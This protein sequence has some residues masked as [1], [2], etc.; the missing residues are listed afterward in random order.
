MISI[1]ARSGCRSRSLEL[2]SPTRIFGLSPSPERRRVR[3][4][5]CTEVA[6]ATEHAPNARWREGCAEP[7][8]LSVLRRTRRT[9][10]PR[11][12][13]TSPLSP[14]QITRHT[15]QSNFTRK[16]LKTND[17]HPKEVTHFFECLIPDFPLA[18]PTL[19]HAA[20]R[21]LAT[22]HSSLATS[23]CTRLPE[24]RPSRPASDSL[25]GGT[26]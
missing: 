1:G 7:L 2:R 25:S 3:L 26:I 12:Q 17:G 16:S 20:E 6:A 13:A 21:F 15:M 9:V 24:S 22:S 23:H 19:R 4:P 5:A 11:T 10:T 8:V 14:R 18:I